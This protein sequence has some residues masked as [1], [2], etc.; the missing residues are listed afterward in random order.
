MGL[1][2]INFE[3]LLWVSTSEMRSAGL[4]RSVVASKDLNVVE[5]TNRLCFKS[6]SKP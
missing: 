1:D 6:T 3:N 4:G 5:L 2:V